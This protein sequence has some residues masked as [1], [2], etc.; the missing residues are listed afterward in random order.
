V[1]AAT[2]DLARQVVSRDGR[3]TRL[4]PRT[5][6]VL[7]HLVAHAGMVVP[8]QALIDA[9]W[10]GTAVTDDSLVQCL[11]EIRRALGPGQDLVRTVRGRGYL[12]DL[13][14]PDRR[15][16]AAAATLAAHPAA[17]AA[18]P[19]PSTEAPTGLRRRFV[20]MTVLAA[21]VVLVTVAGLG[22]RVAPTRRVG[23]SETLNDGARQAVADGLA[24]LRESRAQVDL[25]RARQRFERAI[26]LD[27][28]YAPGHAA[29][30]NILV[31]LSGFGVEP[32]MRV[33]PRAGAA[34]RRAVSLD[35]TLA[36]G[37]QALAHVQTQWEWDWE[38][39]ERSYRRA[40]ALDPTGPF[41]MIYAH[42]LA[43]TGRL[44]A[45]VAESDRWQMP[46]PD[47]PVRLASNCI[48]KYLARRYEAALA[49]C[50]AALAEAPDR[51]LPQVWRALTLSALDR[52]EAA[53]QAAIASRQAMSFTPTWVVG[54]VHARAGRL[55]QAREVVAAIEAQAAA[56]YVPPVDLALLHAAIGDRDR[57][58]DW[59]ERGH[60]ERGRWLELMAVLPPADPLRD[61]PRFKHLLR[62]MR[63]PDRS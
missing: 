42:L 2:V 57:A 15:P 27:P 5:A 59:L 49:A 34:A 46:T 44:D 30:A 12:L 26:T 48:V 36:A 19:L 29:L 50:D 16:A 61:Q 52:H 53:M 3:E 11:V 18:P 43:G 28:G 35:A 23:P 51:S 40:I 63:L 47:A 13:P 41:N 14:G 24:L 62:S 25:E 17:T 32:P 54:Y 8:K 55:D 20:A 33:L 21:A 7:A 58:L 31:L 37:W 4:R 1:G 56:T 9:V 60:R 39:A 10:G 45:A 38:G 6:D 22:P